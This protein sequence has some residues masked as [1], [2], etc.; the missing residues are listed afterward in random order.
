MDIVFDRVVFNGSAAWSQDTNEVSID[1]ADK[2]AARQATNVF[3]EAQPTKTGRGKV[4][5]EAEGY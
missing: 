3:R 2:T 1:A 4:S 5:R